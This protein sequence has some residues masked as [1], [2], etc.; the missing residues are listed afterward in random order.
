MTVSIGISVYP[1]HASSQKELF[2]I[3]DS[4]MYK[5]KE[6]GK[7]TIKFPSENDILSIV[8][9]QKAKSSLLLEAISNNK[10]IPFFQPIQN[11]FD[12]KIQIH[13]L[14]MRIEIDGHL[15]TAADFIEVA[16]G[17][18]L[19]HRMDLIVVEQAFRKIQI[20]RYQGILFINLSPKSLVIGDYTQQLANLVNK[21]NIDKSKIVFEITE[22][23]TVKNFSLLEKF[24]LNLKLDGFQFAIDDFGSGFSSFHYIKKFPIDYLKIDGDFIINI[25]KDSKD[26]AFVQSILTLAKE[27]K[28]KTVAEFVEDEEIVITLKALGVDLLQGYHIGKPSRN[29]TKDEIE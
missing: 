9:E 28:I 29:F 16:E 7:N 24:V 6:E 13:E 21:Y 19:I 14:L 23:E 2:I 3:A 5:A 22:R 4:M 12:D 26:R 17:M 1:Q 15:T 18:S 10:I 25:N 11:S 20:E 8:K 27:L